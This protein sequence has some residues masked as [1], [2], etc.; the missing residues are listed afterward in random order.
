MHGLTAISPESPITNSGPNQDQYQY[1][2]QA[3]A[4]LRNHAL[5][6]GPEPFTAPNIARNKD[7]F[8]LISAGTDRIYG[9]A[10][11]IT[12]FGDVLP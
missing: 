2:L 9:T 1:P 11:D 5:S 12:N 10:D 4:Y 8:I 3:F 6:G 7:S